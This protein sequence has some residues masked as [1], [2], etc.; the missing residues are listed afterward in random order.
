MPADLIEDYPSQYESLLTIKNGKE[1]LFRP[2]LRSDGPLLVDLFNHLSPESIRLRFLTNLQFLPEDLLYRFT[3]LDYKKDFALACVIEEDGKVA[4]IGVGRYMDDPLEGLPDFAIAVRD[5]WQHFGLGKA[6]L[7]KTIAI[8]KEN[9][10]T[11]LGA[12][13]DPQNNVIR[14]LFWDLGFPVKYT[15]RGGFFR[16][17]I[18]TEVAHPV[19]DV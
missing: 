7:V 8:A 1:V 9:G 3:H 16:L 17:E 6:L 13:I 18:L 14:Q 4:I 2:I 19:L 5:D 10:I 12:V 15:L 11:C